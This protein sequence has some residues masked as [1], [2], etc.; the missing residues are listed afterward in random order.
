[1]NNQQPQ[2]DP[3]YIRD[4][5][6]NLYLIAKVG[7][8]VLTPLIRGGGFGL[9][10]PGAFG[11]GALVLML[12]WAAFTPGPDGELVLLFLLFWI[13]AVLVQRQKAINLT[14]QGHHE[15]SRFSGYPVLMLKLLPGLKTE[16]KAKNAEP[17]L[18]LGVGLLVYLGAPALGGLIL[19]S[20]LSLFVTR[21]FEAAAAYR[22]VQHM[23]DA[24]IEVRQAAMRHRGEW[25]EY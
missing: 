24:E 16:L 4:N 8:C 1:M 2:G 20:G 9:E 17:L 13:G 3:F 23:R 10:Y 6:N 12:F 11:L 5:V 7:E 25:D 15:H 14:R 18:C 22:R 21:G 19:F